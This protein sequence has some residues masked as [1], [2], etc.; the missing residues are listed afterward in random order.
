MLLNNT[1]A[2]YKK[3]QKKIII[4]GIL[5]SIIAFP[6]IAQAT[7]IEDQ[8]DK[9][10]A[11]TTGKVKT[12]G[13]TGASIIGFMWAIFKGNPKLAGIIVALGMGMAFYL[14]WIEGG[15]KF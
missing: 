9:I 7:K 6:E 12:I 11:I 10:N 5:T 13:V 4:G 1:K 3:H 2:F 15:M 14:N 8:L